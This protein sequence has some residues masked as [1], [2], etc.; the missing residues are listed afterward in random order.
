MAQRCAPRRRAGRTI[1]TTTGHQSLVGW[2]GE[3]PAVDDCPFR[4][5]EPR[6]IQAAVAFG[7]GCRVLGTRREQ[8]RR[9]GNAVTP[10]AAEF[11]IRA[12]VVCLA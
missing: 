11:L 10:P 6:E 4:M 3:F 5:L 12:G 7:R 8:V 2:P 1:T 9:L